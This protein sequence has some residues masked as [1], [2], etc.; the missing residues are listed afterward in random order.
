MYHRIAEPVSDPWELSVSPENFEQQLRILK[1]L[2]KIISLQELATA[3]H[4]KS[5]RKNT[6]AITFDDGYVDNVKAA[7][8]LLEKYQVPATFFVTS[9]NVDTDREFWWDE[10]EQ[11]ILFS[12]ELPPAVSLTIGTTLIESN[13]EEETRLSPALRLR[14]FT[15]KACTEPP[16]TR[17]AILFYSIWEK[18]RP[19]VHIEQ[20]T[21]LQQIRDIAASPILTRP[22]YRTM[23][24]IELQQLASSDLITIGSHTLTHPALPFHSASYQK[25]EILENRD[26]LG[27]ITG[28][29]IKLL[30]YPFGNYNEDS[31]KILS[32]GG[33]DAAFSTQA[34]AAQSDTPRYTI[35][36][37]QVK[38]VSGA[39][40]ETQIKQWRTD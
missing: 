4:K 39:Q 27:E 31:I 9:G 10:L 13:L 6:I 23:S 37:F 25:K 1:N 35:G 17:R 19:L 36:R 12:E 3:V 40:L 7:K 28:K 8:P 2:G 16:P 29:E 30:A 11:L 38:N 18:L 26:A 32:D 5:V 14:H 20:Q 34:R 21:Y 22:E 24:K 33:F 15:W